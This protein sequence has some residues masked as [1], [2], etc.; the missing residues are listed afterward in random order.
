MNDHADVEQLSAYLDGA[1]GARERSALERH[2][3]ACADC[4]ARKAALEGA[5]R[6]LRGLPAV[7]VSPAESDAIR[8]AV[9]RGATR[10]AP[11]GVL[12]WRPRWSPRAALGGAAAALAAVAAVVVGF[13]VLRS[14]PSGH[15]ASR[16]FVSGAQAPVALP[17]PS[18][19]TPSLAND[20][21]VRAFAISLPGVANVLGTSAGGFAPNAAAPS[22]SQGSRLGILPPAAAAPVPTP[23]VAQDQ[24]APTAPALGGALAPAPTLGACERTAVPSGAPPLYGTAVV[25]QGAPAWLIAFAAAPASGATPGTATN[26][27]TVEIRSQS[28]CGLLDTATL[29]P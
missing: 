8:R 1:L 28:A 12:R 22:T 2:L 5:V 23:G 18:P 10:G 9:L 15:T 14:G 29:V 25:Y 3:A 21:E 19:S 20:A 11:A 6:S 7:V 27:V 17:S 16:T 24:T 26:Q 13:A 4:G